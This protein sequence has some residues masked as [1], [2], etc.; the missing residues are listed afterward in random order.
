MWIRAGKKN[1]TTNKSDIYI[2][3]Y[4]PNREIHVNMCI[5]F[6]VSVRERRSWANI[7]LKPDSQ[8]NITS[9]RL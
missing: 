3:V 7:E 1:G 4:V 9:I 2:I 5:A 8:Y 6:P